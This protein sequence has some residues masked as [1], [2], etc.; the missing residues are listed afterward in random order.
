MDGEGGGSDGK[1][2]AP[3]RGATGSWKHIH[4]LLL[5]NLNALGA[6]A[7]AEQLGLALGLKKIIDITFQIILEKQA[8]QLV[9]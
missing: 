9:L 3:V 5:I 4:Q 6:F 8:S 2:S 1:F 7:I